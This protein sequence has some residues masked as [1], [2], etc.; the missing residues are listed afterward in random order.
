DDLAIVE[1]EAC[2]MLKNLDIRKARH[3]LVVDGSDAVHQTVLV[4]C[5]LDADDNGVTRLPLTNKVA[6]HLWRVLQIRQQ[7][8][9]GVAFG[10]EDCV[11]RGADVAEVARIQNYLYARIIFRDPAQN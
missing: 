5:V 2:E 4:A 8:D 3:S 1:A 6:E 7:N 10:F 9:D 11:L